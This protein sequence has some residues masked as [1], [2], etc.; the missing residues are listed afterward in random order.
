M[1]QLATQTEAC[2]RGTCTWSEWTAVIEQWSQ[3]KFGQLRTCTVCGWREHDD[4]CA[5]RASS[6]YKMLPP[7]A[8]TD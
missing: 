6:V 3:I 2:A 5:A 8:P 4:W 7:A 1:N